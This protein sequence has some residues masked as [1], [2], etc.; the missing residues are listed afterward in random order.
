LHDSRAAI[1]FKGGE[2]EGIKRLNNYLFESKAI[3]TYKQTRNGLVGSEYSSKFSA[4]LSLGC[5]SAKTIYHT[6][7]QI[8]KTI[9]SQRF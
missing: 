3:A 5:L 4:W 7:K 6:I 9:F 1:H 2:T 8:R